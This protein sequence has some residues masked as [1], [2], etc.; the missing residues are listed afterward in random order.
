MKAFKAT[1][2]EIQHI[3]IPVLAVKSSRD[4][5]ADQRNMDILQYDNMKCSNSGGIDIL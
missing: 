2:N 4:C 5:K 3:I 1:T